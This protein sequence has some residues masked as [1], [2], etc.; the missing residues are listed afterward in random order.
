MPKTAKKF[1]RKICGIF[2]K[3][4]GEEFKAFSTGNSN[5]EKLLDSAWRL[6]F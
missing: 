5:L 2:L 3:N 1:S 6:G 4:F